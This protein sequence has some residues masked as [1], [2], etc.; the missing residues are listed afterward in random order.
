MSFVPQYDDSVYEINTLGL[1]PQHL[2]PNLYA[3]TLSAMQLLDELVALKPSLVMQ[4]PWPVA[5]GSPFS[6]NK[7]VPFIKLPSGFIG[8]AGDY[9]IWWVR[10]PTPEGLALR[11]C[12]TQLLADEAAWLESQQG[13]N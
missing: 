13:G 5:Q 10:V 8:S 9:Q 6:F 4:Y 12:T 7:Q 3:T 11:Y 1:P 2:N